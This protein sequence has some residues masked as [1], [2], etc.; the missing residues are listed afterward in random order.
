MVTPK[1]YLTFNLPNGALRSKNFTKSPQ[2][3]RKRAK[4]S[5]NAQKR[6]KKP[7]NVRNAQKHLETTR[8]R[9]KRPTRE[10]CSTFFPQQPPHPPIYAAAAHRPS[11]PP[12]QPTT[13]P[14][15]PKTG[16]NENEILNSQRYRD[17]LTIAGP[18]LEDDRVRQASGCNAP[19]L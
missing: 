4:T 13:P 1:T 16:K 7:K 19:L 3:I 10:K 14:H 11:K 9:L 5:E 18:S 12:H 6:P 17:A 15:P 2:N 8:K